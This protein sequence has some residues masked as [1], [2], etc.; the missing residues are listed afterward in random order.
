[1]GRNYEVINEL[2]QVKDIFP[3]DKLNNLIAY[4]LKNVIELQNSIKIND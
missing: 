3:D 4:R 2:K 1:M